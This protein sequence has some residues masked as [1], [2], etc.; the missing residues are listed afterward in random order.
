M[1]KL[2]GIQWEEDDSDFGL[3]EKVEEQT[4]FSQMLEEKGDDDEYIARGQKI[5]GVVAVISADSNDILIDLGGKNSGVIEKQEFQDAEGQLT[6]KVGDTI[7]AFVVSKKGGEIVLSNSMAQSVKSAEDLQ[8]AYREKRP[9]R[10]RVIKVNK[11]GYEVTVFGKNCFCPVSQIDTRFVENPA[12]F[13]NQELEFLIQEFGENGRNI[14]LT[15]SKLLKMQAEEKVKILVDNLNPDTVLEGTVT[16]VREFGAFVDLG[17]VEG[18]VHISQLAHQRIERASEFVKRG[19][20]V[21]V[22][23]L[24]IENDAAG[25]PKISLSMKAAARDPWEDMSDQIKISENYTGKVVRLMAFGAFIELKPGIEALL[26]I[27][28][29]SWVK[30]VH[31][32]SDVVNVGDTVTVT[33]RDI[34][35]VAKRISLTMKQVENDPWYKATEQF[36]IGKKL[37]V[38]VERLKPFGAIC[39]MAEGIGGLLPM[40][41]IKRKFGEAYKSACV[42]GKTVDVQIQNVSQTERKILLGLPGLE[43]EDADQKDFHEYVR[44]EKEK[45]ATVPVDEARTGSFGALLNAKLKGRD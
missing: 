35:P 1:G 43:E 19:E 24:K 4:D 26:H 7:V 33:V 23:I 11:G 18:L 29:M 38:K 2:Q 6:I 32:P 5:S 22:K 15:R 41:T 12:E 20:K 17:G 44:A 8:N 10:G 3:T 31:H 13:V 40:A 36:P 39:E 42:P 14:V 37:T 21:R 9:V 28:E 34:D 25:R 27:S 30:R 16:E 45:V